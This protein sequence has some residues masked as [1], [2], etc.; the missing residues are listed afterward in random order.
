MASVILRPSSDSSVSHSKST[1]SNGY[2][3][4]NEATS[5]GDSTYIYQSLTSTSRSTVTSTFG[6]DTS[7][8]PT[9]AKINSISVS[10]TA[11]DSDT[12]VSS[13]VTTNVKQNGTTVATASNSALGTSYA[14]YTGSG[15][16]SSVSSLTLEI[17]TTGK[18]DSSKDSDGY[19]RVT[20][21]FV[22]V[23]YTEQSAT[24][25]CKAIAGDN[26]LT[27]VVSDENPTRGDDVIFS[28][29][30]SKYSTFIGWFSD[31]ACTKPYPESGLNTSATFTVSNVQTDI[32]LYAKATEDLGRTITLTMPNTSSF[33]IGKGVYLGGFKQD[34]LTE[35]DYANLKAGK[36]SS[37][38]SEKVWE[39]NSATG[40]TNREHKTSIFVPKGCLLA[41]YGDPSIS[42]NNNSELYIYETEG[43]PLSYIPY[44]QV[45]CDDN[46]DYI[47]GTEYRCECTANA[48]I[49]IA[50]ANV[51]YPELIQGGYATFTATVM[52]GY[53]WNGWY[54][55][56]SRKT[57]ISSNQT[58]TEQAPYTTSSI[59]KITYLSRYA[60]A[61]PVDQD[62]GLYLK[63][64]GAWVTVKQL[65]V[66]ENGQWVFKLTTN[67]VF[68]TTKNYVKG[69]V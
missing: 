13:S 65:Y 68:D 64:N 54:S 23:D 60:Y 69:E 35:A 48:E 56:S 28:A 61:E 30:F 24:V 26:I 19:I 66:K 16:A 15:T 55:D 38:S 33:F 32:T 9:G 2:A 1:G 45:V 46:H 3:L 11:R 7:A 50:S 29:T 51:D 10:V 25:I 27:A 58:Y 59:V 40:A 5:D 53:K 21:A 67:G 12:D 63:Q 42:S 20:Q 8:I 47:V 41:M 62:Y 39:Q 18:K 22:T 52:D 44:Y 14:T 6:L 34:L 43:T 49:G 37:I 36:F 17:L 31:E 4:I 57:L